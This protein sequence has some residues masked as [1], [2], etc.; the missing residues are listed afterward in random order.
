NIASTKVDGGTDVNFGELTRKMMDY[1]Q[2][3]D[4]VKIHYNNDVVDIKKTKQ[5]QWE[6]KVKNDATG[7]IAYYNADFV[8]IGAG[9]SAIPLLHKSII[10]YC[11]NFVVFQI[12]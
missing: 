6:V 5:K 11:K 3:D 1:L 4:S 12:S 2:Q 8:F 9:G 10:R 7:M